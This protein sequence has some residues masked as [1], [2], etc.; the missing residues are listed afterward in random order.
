MEDSHDGPRFE[1][2]QLVVGKQGNA[3]VYDAKFLISILLVYVAKGD[4]HIDSVETDNMID[5]ISTRFES[6]G[7][8]AMGLLSDAVRTITDGGDLIGKLRE[9]S[10]GLS[11]AEC[12]DIFDML[13]E[14]IMADGEL[15]DGEGRTVEVAGTI[16]GLSQEAIHAGIRAARRRSLG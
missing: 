2:A 15:A 14:V 4:G 10:Q 6:T 12:S 7:A 3:A 8:E 11:E 13:L 9:I 16:L 1:G 5:I